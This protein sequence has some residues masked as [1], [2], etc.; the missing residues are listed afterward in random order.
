ML[1]YTFEARDAVNRPREV[2]WAEWIVEVYDTEPYYADASVTEWTGTLRA[3]GF[4]LMSKEDFEGSG[5]ECER[6]EPLGIGGCSGGHECKYQHEIVV[7]GSYD[8][9][10]RRLNLLDERGYMVSADILA[11]DQSL[12]YVR[13]DVDILSQF[14]LDDDNEAQISLCDSYCSW[15]ASARGLYGD[16]VPNF[17]T[18]E[19]ARVKAI[20]LQRDQAEVRVNPAPDLEERVVFLGDQAEVEA[21]LLGHWDVTVVPMDED[22]V[23]VERPYGVLTYDLE[24]FEVERATEAP[25]WYVRGALRA[26]EGCVR[27]AAT[28]EASG[29]CADFPGWTLGRCSGGSCT[30]GDE[31]GNPVEMTYDHLHQTLSLSNLSA[32]AFAEDGNGAVTYTGALDIDWRSLDELTGPGVECE[33]YCSWG[34]RGWG[35]YEED[36][37][38]RDGFGWTLKLSRP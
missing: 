22:A 28:F 8:E 26:K 13:V 4:C 6:F 36:F 31:L 33:R 2:G 20:E 18:V 19:G 25:Y 3:T 11:L 35:S 16:T 14:F 30:A 9:D 12:G 5:T 10:E 27:D 37:P 29:P 34:S 7:T 23:S 38:Y 17:N 21:E 1:R 32:D 24:L 15:G